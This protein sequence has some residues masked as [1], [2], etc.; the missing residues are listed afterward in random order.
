M[1]ST[2]P[3]LT[4]HRY[5]GFWIRVGAALID[6][7]LLGFA[8][9]LAE[10][11]TTSVYSATVTPVSLDAPI[12]SAGFPVGLAA[13]LV[14][15]DVTLCVVYYGGLE[16]SRAQ[17]T[18]GKQ[19]CK[20]RVVGSRGQRLSFR[21]AAGRY[22]AKILSTLTFGIG[23]LMVGLDERKRGLH[24]RVARTF[25]V[26]AAPAAPPRSWPAPGGP[27]PPPPVDLARLPPPPPR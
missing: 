13:L 2:P 20:L 26:H 6:G 15:V 4:E 3:P 19:V 23:Y 9:R 25:V 27:P 22:A 11:I 16:S 18:L 7:F 10:V 12:W 5:A 8:L 24:D 21:H 14:L 1:S 17:A